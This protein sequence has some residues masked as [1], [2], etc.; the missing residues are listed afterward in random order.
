MLS[1][2]EIIDA[3]EDGQYSN[4]KL[5]DE[6]PEE[7][8][9][10]SRR[11]EWIRNAEAELKAEAA[12]AKAAQRNDEAEASLQVEEVSEATG[13]KQR[14]KRAARRSL[15]ARK[16]ADEAQKLAME[17]AE[18]AGLEL[19]TVDTAKADPVSVS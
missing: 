8:Q 3:Q 11:L 18:A 10:R 16:R 5:R 13:Y 1:K 12:A 7:L 14:S 17:K 4:S 6:L 15:R 19:S 2:V 9:R